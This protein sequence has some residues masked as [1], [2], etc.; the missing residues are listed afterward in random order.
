ML[1]LPDETVYLQV[2]DKTY[3]HHRELQ[4]ELKLAKKINRSSEPIHLLLAHQHRLK[5]QLAQSE[6][7]LKKL[8]NFAALVHQMIVQN[9]VTVIQQDAGSFLRWLKVLKE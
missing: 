9:L 2:K 7:N 6:S 3:E 8:G 5:I 1:I 4:M